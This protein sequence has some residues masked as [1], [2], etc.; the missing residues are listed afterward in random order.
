MVVVL[1]E[2]DE[3][4]AGEKVLVTLPDGKVYSGR[5]GAYGVRKVTG[6]EKGATCK[7]TFPDLDKETREKA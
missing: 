3:P 6:V 4:V 2:A 5:T 7:I 1:D